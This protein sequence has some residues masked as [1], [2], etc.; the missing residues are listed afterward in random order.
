[1]LFYNINGFFD[2][3]SIGLNAVTMHAHWIEG[4]MTIRAIAIYVEKA[5]CLAIWR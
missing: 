5:D 4:L 3:S 2:I 1:M